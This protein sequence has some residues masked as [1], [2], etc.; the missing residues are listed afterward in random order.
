[1]EL[2]S[3]FAWHFAD[4]RGSND[5]YTSRLGKRDLRL[6]TEAQPYRDILAAKMTR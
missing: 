5:E 2:R 1:V 4:R 6:T 3:G